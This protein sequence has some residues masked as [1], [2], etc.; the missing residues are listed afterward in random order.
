[1]IL[2]LYYIF[3]NL[4]KLRDILSNM[5]YS[6]LAIMVLCANVSLSVTQK[7]S[8]TSEESQNQKPLRSRRSFVDLPLLETKLKE[9]K[10]NSQPRVVLVQDENGKWVPID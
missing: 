5:P 3:L 7:T 4:L 1:M 9:T 8:E 2:F 6:D 10:E